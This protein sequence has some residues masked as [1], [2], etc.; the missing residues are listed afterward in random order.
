[1]SL[2]EAT[3]KVERLE[4]SFHHKNGAYTCRCVPQSAAFIDSNEQEI[5]ENGSVST[6]CEKCGGKK[7]II[8]IN[9]DS[10]SKP[11]GADAD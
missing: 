5:A 7:I 8:R 3:R 1:M 10:D 11:V 2:R 4:A 9:Y 6:L